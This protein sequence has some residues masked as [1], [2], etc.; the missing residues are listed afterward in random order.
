MT[1]KVLEWRWPHLV[2]SLFFFLYHE[3]WRRLIKNVTW[4]NVAMIDIFRTCNPKWKLHP[5]YIFTLFPFPTISSYPF[6]MLK[7]IKFPWIKATK[8]TTL[9]IRDHTLIKHF[10]CHTYL[11]KGNWLKGMLARIALL[12]SH[13]RVHHPNVTMVE[14]ITSVR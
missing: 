4:K 14:E 11:L 9:I 6:S 8:K 2:R 12:A 3:N 13:D 7:I 1:P 5:S 10:I